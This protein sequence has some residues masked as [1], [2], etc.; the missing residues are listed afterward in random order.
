MSSMQLRI[1]TVGRSAGYLSKRSQSFS[2]QAEKLGQTSLQLRTNT[3]KHKNRKLKT[4]ARFLQKKN[5]RIA[6]VSSLFTEFP[7]TLE[8]D[9]SFNYEGVCSLRIFDNFSIFVSWIPRETPL[10]RWMTPTLIG[11]ATLD[12]TLASNQCTLPPLTTAAIIGF[13]CNKFT[14]EVAF[15]HNFCR[16]WG[17]KIVDVLQ[18]NITVTIQGRLARGHWWRFGYSAWFDSGS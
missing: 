13:A 7:H 12:V 17:K 2:S 18:V 6:D 8:Y 14:T 11:R 4:D 1:V 15:K 5:S 16:K 10:N 3:S 9:T